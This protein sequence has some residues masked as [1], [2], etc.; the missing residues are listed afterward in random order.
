MAARKLTPGRLSWKLTLSVSV[1]D[2][3]SANHGTE[4]AE[5]SWEVATLLTTHPS[6]IGHGVF[7]QAKGMWDEMARLKMVGKRPTQKWEMIP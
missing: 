3:T 1:D 7:H 5:R 4:L 6:L 2:P